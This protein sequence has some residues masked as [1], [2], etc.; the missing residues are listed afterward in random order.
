MIDD[1]T[2]DYPFG[3]P[4]YQETRRSIIAAVN[5]TA[6]N[7]HAGTSAGA[8]TA[9]L[10]RVVTRAMQ[11]AYSVGRAD[12]RRQDNGAVALAAL[13]GMPPVPCCCTRAVGQHCPACHGQ[14]HG[15]APTNLAPPAIH[16]DMPG[17]ETALIPRVLV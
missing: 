6:I 7:S 4:T 14:G 17:E 9:E 8:L 5:G 16:V 3:D 12:E 10:L 15:F 2:S 13:D 11:A 1:P